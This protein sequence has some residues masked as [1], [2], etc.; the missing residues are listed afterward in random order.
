VA[1]GALVGVL[2]IAAAASSVAPLRIRCAPALD[3]DICHRTVSASLERG[4]APFHP[5]I[6]SAHVEP[7]EAPTSG[8]VGHRATVSFDLLGIPGSTTVAL[9]YDIGA[10]WG[11][12][13]SRTAAELAAWALLDTVVVV[14]AVVVL[15]GLVL[16]LVHRHRRVSQPGVTPGGS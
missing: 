2:L 4:L 11:G 6:V 1:C 13:P 12:V 16:R 3:D 5:L 15:L 7:G 10:H 14:G 8:Q 9:Y